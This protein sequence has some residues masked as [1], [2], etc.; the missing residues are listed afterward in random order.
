ML[1]GGVGWNDRLASALGQPVPQSSSVIGPV[2]DQPARRRDTGE[3]GRRAVQ[4]MGLTSG[5]REGPWATG[6]VGQGVN[7]GRPSA[8]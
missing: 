2:R 5:Q 1:A 6:L 8:A 7:L 4:I 3:K